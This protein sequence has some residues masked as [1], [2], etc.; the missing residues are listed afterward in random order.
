MKIPIKVYF[1]SDDK[2][3]TTTGKNLDD[4][5]KKIYKKI[6]KIYDECFIKKK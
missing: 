6:K 5:K 3:N 2:S 1:E 4:K